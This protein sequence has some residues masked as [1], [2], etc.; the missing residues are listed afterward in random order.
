MTAARFAIAAAM[1]DC[2]GLQEAMRDDSAGALV[3]FAGW[4][5][6]SNEGHDVTALEYE[7]FAEL[8]SIEGEKILAEAVERFA[9]VDA[10]A[11]HRTGHLAIGDCAVWIGVT[12]RHRGEAFA[13][14]RYVIDEIKHR[15]PIWKK[16]YYTGQEPQWVNC[17]HAHGHA[18]PAAITEDEFY[19]RQTILPQIGAA[20]QA[21]L[22]AARVL[23]VGVGGLGTAAAAALAGAG[24][25]TIGLAEPDVLS[26]SNLH[27]QTLYNAADIGK[28]KAD[29]A[30]ARL[31]ALNPL[32]RIETHP[33]RVTGAN[34]GN[35]FAAYDLVLDCTDN[36]TAKYALNAA[37]VAQG[38]LL[39][40]AS[41]YQFEGQLLTIDPNG[42]GGC[43]RCL[44]PA[45]PPPGLVGDCAEAGVL[46]TVPA[47][48]G[49]LQANEA[50][51]IILGLGAVSGDMLLFDLLSLQSQR[52]ARTRRADCESCGAQRKER[53]AMP[54]D[55]TE[56]DYI[57]QAGDTDDGLRRR[58]AFIDVRESVEL[59]ALPVPGALHMPTSAF[60][61][62][63]LTA[64]K[65]APLLLICAKG[66]RSRNA[67]E[68]LRGQGWALA[69]NLVGGV[70]ALP[71]PDSA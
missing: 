9:L 7:A 12:A 2:A 28:P 66:A 70:G 55:E 4:V 17:Q 51:K 30:A 38:K 45:P 14:C 56:I 59:A 49:A 46:G 18:A 20:G 31:R 62:S 52:L 44:F 13:A 68:Y 15:L 21:K 36:F 40:Q 53:N 43:L 16:E 33:T 63:I 11:V 25:G 41:I 58:F 71:G 22:G 29:L 39:V 23:I 61:L 67:A 50:I 47:V 26:A 24:I 54:A 34:A 42:D 57:V 35:L 48:F 27:R 6:N 60:D 69:Y 10:R 3:T 1:I 19:A 64:P 37:A 65:D 8:A 5:R 32:I